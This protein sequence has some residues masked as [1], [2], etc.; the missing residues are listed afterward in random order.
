MIYLGLIWLGMFLSIPTFFIPE[1]PYKKQ[2]LCIFTILSAVAVLESYGTYTSLNG[3][4]NVWAFNIV[5][6]YLETLLF[7]YFFALVFTDPKFFK[8]IILLASGFLIWGII[9]TLWIQTFDLL[10]TYSFIV[11]SILVI[12]CSIYFFYRIF[13][14]NLF[15]DQNLFSVPSFWIVT[16]VLFFYACSFL[17]FASFRLMDES[18]YELLGKIYSLIKVLG[19]LMYL[20]MGMAFYSPLVFQKMGRKN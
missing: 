7:L 6:V 17:F 20:V 15:R 8:I 19:V 5:F 12:G 10:Q 16:F 13:D 4:N 2:H 1:N 3:I 14:G 11:G 9:N 18:N